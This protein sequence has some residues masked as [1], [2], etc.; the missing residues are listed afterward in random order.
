MQVSSKADSD[1]IDIASSEKPKNGG[2]L[3]S[4]TSH[5]MVSLLN[6]SLEDVQKF[7]LMLGESVSCR[8]CAVGENLVVVSEHGTV[9]IVKPDASLVTIAI[10]GLSAKSEPVALAGGKSF[11][12]Y[13]KGFLG[14]I[15]Y[16]EGDKCLNLEHPFEIPGIALGSPALLKSGGKTYIGFVTQA[17]EMNVWRTD[18]ADGAQIEGFPMRIGGVFMTN[19]VASEKYFYALSNDALLY[20]ISLD[21]KLLTVQIPNA[22]AKEGY[23][24]VRDSEHNGKLSVFVCADANV[25]YGF[26]ENLELLSGYP[27]TGWG[28]PVFADVNGD[29]IGECIALTID[30]KLV[31]WKVR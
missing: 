20:R 4:V 24:S 23:L 15:Y 2:V 17:G 6:A 10:P 9:F 30:K 3:W 8:P 27:L 28:K 29:K 14:K 31:A 12:I 26:N 11:A 7:P 21:G 1:K 16:F 13:S 5:G 22:T 19:V 18:T 25:I